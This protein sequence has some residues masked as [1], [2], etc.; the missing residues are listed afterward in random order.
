MPGGLL[1]VGQCFDG[2]G[3]PLPL[4]AMSAEAR[5]C[6]ASVKV[7]TRARAVGDAV[8]TVADVKLWDKMRALELLATYLGLLKKQV[9]HSG[10]IDLVAR[11]QAARQ[12]GRVA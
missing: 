11:L 10:G 7:V 4:A 12:R 5:A 9:E 2:Q 3:H 8:V 1:D 6:V